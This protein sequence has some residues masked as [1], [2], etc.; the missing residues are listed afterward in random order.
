MEF[1]DVVRGN[2]SFATDDLEDF[3]AVAVYG[4]ARLP[5]IQGHDDL[6]RLGQNADGVD[7]VGRRA[8]QIDPA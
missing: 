5:A 2:V 1:D 7:H 8:I 6:F 3:V 4:G